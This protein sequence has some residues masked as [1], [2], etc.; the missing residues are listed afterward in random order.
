MIYLFFVTLFRPLKLNRSVGE[1]AVWKRSSYLYAEMSELTPPPPERMPLDEIRRPIHSVFV[2][3]SSHQ[4]RVAASWLVPNALPS[5]PSPTKPQAPEAASPISHG[6]Y[7]SLS[8]PPST[9]S[10]W[11]TPKKRANTREGD[12]GRRREEKRGRK[13]KGKPGGIRTQSALAAGT[14]RRRA[15]VWETPLLVVLFTSLLV[16][17]LICVRGF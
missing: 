15:R 7:I 4:A 8:R 12:G 10:R 16:W 9:R 3:P 1:T 14:K 13:Q 17:R 11:R 2:F 5:F 6:H